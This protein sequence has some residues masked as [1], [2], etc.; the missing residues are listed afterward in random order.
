MRKFLALIILVLTFVALPGVTSMATP[1]TMRQEVALSEPIVT[2]HRGAI[3]ISCPV[4]GRSYTFQIYAI[5]GQL[6]KKGGK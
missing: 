1:S 4:N 3:E 5:T 2:S 6:L